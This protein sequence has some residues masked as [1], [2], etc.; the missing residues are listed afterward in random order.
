MTAC[1]LTSGGLASSPA[2]FSGTIA[3]NDR[4]KQ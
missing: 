2:S 4:M 3:G 1:V